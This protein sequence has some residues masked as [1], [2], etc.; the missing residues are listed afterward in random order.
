MTVT[1]IPCDDVTLDLCHRVIA[2]RNVATMH[3]YLLLQQKPHSW[4]LSTIPYYCRLSP[5]C[6]PVMGHYER[7]V[8]GQPY[9]RRLTTGTIQSLQARQGPTDDA[10]GP[11]FRH[12][13]PGLLQT[14]PL[15]VP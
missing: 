5:E 12:Q 7:Q 1:C 10:R 13:H 9:D 15:S 2:L 6:T 11:T 14:L 3:G 8:P 4:F